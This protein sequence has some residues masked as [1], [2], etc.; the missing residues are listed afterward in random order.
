MKFIRGFTLIELLVVISIIALLISV[1]L[2]SLQNAREAA[3]AVQC[4]SNERQ[5]FLLASLY[6]DDYDDYLVRGNYGDSLDWMEMFQKKNYVENSVGRTMRACPSRITDKSPGDYSLNFSTSFGKYGQRGDYPN[7]SQIIYFG[8]IY[9]GV[10]SPLSSLY[11]DNYMERAGNRH[12]QRF[13]ATYLDGH[14]E[15]EPKPMEDPVTAFG[16]HPNDR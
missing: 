7:A 9:R 5:L 3:R 2:P 11:R 6:S 13:N 16:P 8:E 15:A 10:T 4:S 14:I 12:N 1:L